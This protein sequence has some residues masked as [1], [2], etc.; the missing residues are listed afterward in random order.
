MNGVITDK[1]MNV[2][3]KG[4][5]RTIKA[6]IDNALKSTD[7]YANNVEGYILVRKHSDDS[8]IGYFYFTQ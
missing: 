8:L 4:K 1:N 7:W 2:L 6:T 5:G 3:F